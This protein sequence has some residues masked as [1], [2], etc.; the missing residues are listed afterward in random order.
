MYARSRWIRLGTEQVL[1]EY[2]KARQVSTKLYK[3]KNK[4]M[5]DSTPASTIKLTQK[6]SKRDWQKHF[7]TLNNT[8]QKEEEAEQISDNRDKEEGERASYKY[9]RNFNWEKHHD[10]V[11][12]IMNLKYGGEAILKRIHN[13]LVS[14]E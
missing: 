5:W 8:T 6:K 10:Q 2:R 4:N 12:S 3:Q 7:T 9:L 14:V 13:F 1:N 11:T